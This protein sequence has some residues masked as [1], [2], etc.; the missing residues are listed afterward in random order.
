MKDKYQS[1]LSD[2]IFYSPDTLTFYKISNEGMD[3]DDVRELTTAVN[4][5]L[6]SMLCDEAFDYTES[7][8]VACV[9]R[10]RDANEEDEKDL[11][12]TKYFVNVVKVKTNTAELFKDPT[13][14]NVTSLRLTKA[15]LTASKAH[16]S[17][18]RK[19]DDSPYIN[20]LIEVQSLL[21]TSANVKDEDIIIAGL[22]HDVIEDS[23]VTQMQIQ[24]EFG[25]RIASLV[26]AVTDDKTLPL[27]KRRELAI[28]K[29]ENAPKSVKL[30]KLADICSNAMAIPKGWNIERI[31][32]YFD[33]LDVIVVK[34]SNVSP[35]LTSCYEELRKPFNTH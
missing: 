31:T 13:S 26:A 21:A 16:M 7:W 2:N 19:S 23:D 30:I 10:Y 11:E 32:S 24:G 4:S 1:L 3:N 34:C 18:R 14:L 22:L 12:F 17:Q 6:H 25:S 27:E 5:Y 8:T 20:H 15:L 28:K 29:L 9:G 35:E 33:W